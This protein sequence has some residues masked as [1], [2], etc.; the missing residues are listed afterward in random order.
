[1]TE[2]DAVRCS[3][4]KLKNLWYLKVE[5]NIPESFIEEVTDRIKNTNR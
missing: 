2:K 3:N 1:M 4:I 5:V